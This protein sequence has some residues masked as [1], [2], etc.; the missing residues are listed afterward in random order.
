MRSRGRFGIDRNRRHRRQRL[1]RRASRST[2]SSRTASAR[3]PNC[4]S[5]RRPRS[6]A[7]SPRP[8]LRA[9]SPR[10]SSRASPTIDSAPCPSS[11]R[12]VGSPPKR[13]HKGNPKTSMPQLPTTHCS[14]EVWDSDLSTSGKASCLKLAPIARKLT[15]RTRQAQAHLGGNTHEWTIYVLVTSQSGIDLFLSIWRLGG[16]ET[17]YK[18]GTDRSREEGYVFYALQIAD[19][20]V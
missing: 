1:R 11:S 3:W 20:Q 10:R 17:E 8:S 12:S 18:H 14:R 5:H 16:P 15:Q 19:G 9:R 4:S 7:R 13:R 6:S 2:W